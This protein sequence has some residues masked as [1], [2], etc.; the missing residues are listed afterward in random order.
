MLHIVNSILLG[1][2]TQFISI[3]GEDT[4]KPIL[5][6]VHGGPGMAQIG[7]ASYFQKELEQH[8]LVVNWDQ[9]GAGKSY[10]KK[11]PISSMTTQQIVSDAI[12]LSEYLYKHYGNRKIFICGHSWGSAVAI[13]AV[14]QRPDL[15]KAFIGIGQVVN[16]LE[17]QKIAYNYAMQQAENSGMQQDVLALKKLGIAPYDNTKKIRTLV[18][19]LEK[20]NG[21]VYGGTINKL[22]KKGSSLKDYSI[23]D[24]LFKFNRG[25]KFSI[26]YLLPETLKLQLNTEIK[27]L[28]VPCY[29][30]MGKYD[31]QTS[32]QLVEPFVAELK[33]PHKELIVIDS[34]AHM[35]PFEKPRELAKILVEKLPTI[36]E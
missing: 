23:A 19:Y 9:R 15:Y 10:H 25:I 28:Q 26:K 4:S 5:L 21:A 24:W 27:E 1:G 6:M 14:K 16:I 20:Y 7:V 34:C 22:V 18:K 3:S 31:M 36:T 32:L 12:E 33:A 29:F 8:Y 13:Y 30:I 2:I 11:V 35:L 17:G